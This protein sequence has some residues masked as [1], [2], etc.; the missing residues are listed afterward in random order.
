MMHLMAMAV[1]LVAMQEGAEQRIRAAADALER[2]QQEF[3]MSLVE[4]GPDA[5][6]A[7]EKQAPGPNREL[8]KQAIDEIK[9]LKEPIEKL[10]AQLGAEEISARDQATVELARIG[11]PAKPYLVKA[12]GQGNREVGSRASS[13]LERRTIVKDL[14]QLRL[15]ERLEISELRLKAMQTNVEKG[16]TSRRD[17]NQARAALE[18]SRRQAGRITKEAFLESVGKIAAEELELVEYQASQGTV[19][20]LEVLKARLQLLYVDLR[21]GKDVGE[22]I[23]KAFEEASPKIRLQVNRGLAG[24]VE[25][26]NQLLELTQ[27]PNEGI[28]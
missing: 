14:E 17:L 7:L 22:Q 2:A 13:I 12:Q 4:L 11:R 25:A 20:A 10:I 18:R 28:D 24:E 9:R 6:P 3:R 26:L 1:A 19:G 16:I 15:L 23:K 27:D 8:V 21:L 5:I